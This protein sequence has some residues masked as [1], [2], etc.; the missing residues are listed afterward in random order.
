MEE[1]TVIQYKDYLQN[2]IHIFQYINIIFIILG[3]IALAAPLELGFKIAGILFVV[4]A[5]C[6]SYLMFK[7]KSF[8]LS[9][10]KDNWSYRH[11]TYSYD[12]IKS[13]VQTDRHFEIT[14]DKKIVLDIMNFEVESLSEMLDILASH[15]ITLRQKENTSAINKLFSYE[16]MRIITL[17]FA[18]ID[19][20]YL[21]FAFRKLSNM[22]VVAGLLSLVPPVFFA[23]FYVYRLLRGDLE[24]LDK[25]STNLMMVF[26]L[27][28]IAGF[29]VMYTNFSISKFT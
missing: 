9:F 4:L 3:I 18:A 23:I 21:L 17:V 24:V 16:S 2:F 10:N 11:H 22:L 1:K 15:N 5:G 19:W 6:I 20:L 28:V 12:D 27:P 25:L 8:E 26:L 7:T 13:F 14:T 29:I